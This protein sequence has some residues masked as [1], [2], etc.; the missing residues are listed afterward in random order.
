MTHLSF[1]AARDLA[2]ACGLPDYLAED[3]AES[4]LGDMDFAPEDIVLAQIGYAQ[5]DIAEGFDF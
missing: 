3:V 2:A 1:T 4:S 5:R